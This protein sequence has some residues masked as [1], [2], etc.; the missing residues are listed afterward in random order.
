MTILASILDLD[1]SYTLDYINLLFITHDK[2]WSV[3]KILVS[4]Q[5]SGQ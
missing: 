2:Y 1:F 5:D 4:D 3:T